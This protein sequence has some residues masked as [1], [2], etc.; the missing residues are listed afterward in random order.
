MFRRVIMPSFSASVS[1]SSLPFLGLFAVNTKAFFEMLVN[2]YPSKQP[3]ASEYWIFGKIT[4]GT[5]SHIQIL[6]LYGTEL[7]FR[8]KELHSFHTLLQAHSYCRHTT[9]TDQ[10]IHCKSNL[11]RKERNNESG[12]LENTGENLNLVFKQNS[13]CTC[14]S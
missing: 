6:N 4:V 5:Y 9:K 11:P 10:S 8:Y 2:I 14:V 1:R 13:C 12:T 7:I 3:N